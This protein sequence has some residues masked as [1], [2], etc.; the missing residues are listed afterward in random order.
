[1]AAAGAGASQWVIIRAGEPAKFA[2]L[3]PGSYTACVVPF[4]AEVQGMAAMGYV[5][6]HGDKL[7]CFCQQLNVNA[8]PAEQS[9]N[10]AVEIPPF[11]ADQ[12]GSGAGS[13]TK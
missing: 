10:V 2:E 1:M 7:P 3:S 12:T 8:A 6:R 11:I 9:A 4:P 5:E 13:S